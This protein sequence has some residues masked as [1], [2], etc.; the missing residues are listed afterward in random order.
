VLSL[1]ANAARGLLEAWTFLP[2]S[3]RKYLERQRRGMLLYGRQ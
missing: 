1:V 2:T 3:D